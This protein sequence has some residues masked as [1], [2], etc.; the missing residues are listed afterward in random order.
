MELEKAI[1]DMIE[2]KNNLF[3]DNFSA[4]ELKNF[5]GKDGLGFRTETLTNL[6]RVLTKRHDYKDAN[7]KEAHNYRTAIFD[8]SAVSCR[9]AAL[10]EPDFIIAVQRSET[11]DDAIKAHIS[12]VNYLKQRGY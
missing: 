12:A 2:G 11:F 4:D 3:A 10:D 5:E 6:Y 7:G 8:D 1:K 9:K